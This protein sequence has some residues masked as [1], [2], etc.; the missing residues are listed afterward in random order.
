MP[1][2]DVKHPAPAASRSHDPP[3]SGKDMVH[4]RH[5]KVRKSRR[6]PPVKGAGA[7]REANAE[8]EDRPAQAQA[9]DPGQRTDRAEVPV[10]LRLGLERVGLRRWADGQ[11]LVFAHESFYVLAGLWLSDRPARNNGR[12]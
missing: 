3:R 7:F 8:R 1:A 2:A 6:S 9:S 4:Q 10:Q 12:I 5:E 11:Q